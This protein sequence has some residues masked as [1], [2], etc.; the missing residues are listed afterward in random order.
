MKFVQENLTA[1]MDVPRLPKLPNCFLVAAKQDRAEF[2]AHLCLAVAA[3]GAI[4]I[5]TLQMIRFVTHSEQ[6]VQYLPPNTITGQ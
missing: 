5:C 6:I 4:L 3:L 1:P 2:I